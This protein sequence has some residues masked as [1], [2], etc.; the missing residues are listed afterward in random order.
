MA[1]L[2]HINKDFVVVDVIVVPDTVTEQTAQT[3]GSD[4]GDGRWLLT[5]IDGSF[6]KEYA[7]IGSIYRVDF[8]AFQPPSPARGWVFNDDS[9]MWESPV[10]MPASLGPWDWDEDTQS[11]V[12]YSEAES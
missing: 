8:D 5:S 12:T 11:W 2:A 9:W 1:Y 3:Y 6:R 7:G 4:F 10:P